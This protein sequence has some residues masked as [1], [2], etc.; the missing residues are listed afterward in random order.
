MTAHAWAR[1]EEQLVLALLCVLLLLL[2]GVQAQHRFLIAPEE[3]DLA[4]GMHKLSAALSRLDKQLSLH[5]EVLD[6]PSVHSWEIASGRGKAAAREGAPKRADVTVVLRRD[7]WLRIAQGS[8]NPFDAFA[9][10]KLLV[11]GDTE[12][13]KRLV[14]YL[15][16]PRV[17]YVSPC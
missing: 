11:G 4:E 8:L 1:R 7:T 3:N 2:V 13:A 14:E 6:G 16:D 12:I 15:S 9:S 5:I 17:P 10:G